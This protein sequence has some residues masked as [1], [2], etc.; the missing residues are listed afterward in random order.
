MLLSNEERESFRTAPEE[1]IERAVTKYVAES[2]NNRFAA[3]PDEPMWD[4]PLVG[5][6]SGDDPLFGEYKKIIGDFHLTPR[7]IIE[8]YLGRSHSGDAETMRAVSVI[9]FVLPATEETRVGNRSEKEI[10]SLRWNQMR[11]HGQESIDRLS[12]YLVVLI[13][14]MGGMAVAPDLSRD[15]AIVSQP[16]GLSSNWSQRHAAYAAGLGSFGLSDGFI[17]PK[18]TAMRLG[19]V[20]CNLSLAPTQRTASGPYDNCLFF[21]S[22]RCGKCAERCPVGA[23]GEKGHDKVKCS[24]YLCA[25]PEIARSQGRA[26]GYVGSQ[27][28]GCGFCQTAVPCESRIPVRRG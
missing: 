15:W 3:F 17:T 24:A 6:A 26:E 5:F 28:F 22:G 1:F 16:A 18:G 8:T 20:V 12:R 10:C 27:Y 7:E 19:S 23:I 9:S 25:M 14:E 4:A 13:E 2:P 21:Q 11:F